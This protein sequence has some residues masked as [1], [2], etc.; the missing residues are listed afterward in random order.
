[1]TKGTAVS[2][3]YHA[4]WLPAHLFGP[5][6]LHFHDLIDAHRKYRGTH[7]SRTMA[8]LYI[9]MPLMPRWQCGK[10]EGH[11]S[12]PIS[13]GNNYCL[14]KTICK[15][16]QFRRAQKKKRFVNFDKFHSQRQSSLKTHLSAASLPRKQLSIENSACFQSLVQF[17]CPSS[18]EFEG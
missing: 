10:P 18:L 1:M 14:Q 8:E 2:F 12:S 7:A 11:P 4:L 16:V 13:N 15:K 9:I 17:L 5:N 6:P 3:C